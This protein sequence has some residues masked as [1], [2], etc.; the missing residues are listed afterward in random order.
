MITPD[1]CGPLPEWAKEL[2]DVA[3]KKVDADL[4]KYYD[5]NKHRPVDIGWDTRDLRICA[6][7]RVFKE[8]IQRYE[9]NGWECVWIPNATDGM[10]S[11]YLVA[12]GKYAKE[13]DK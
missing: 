4:K 3:E 9:E 7:P 12:K 2:M 5:S 13:E 8:F 11:P 1:E 10:T 6:N